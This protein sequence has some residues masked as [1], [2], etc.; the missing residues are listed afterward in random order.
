MKIV[1]SIG[2]FF[3]FCLFSFISYEN[4][5]YEITCEEVKVIEILSAKH[6]SVDVRLSNNKIETVYQPSTVIAKDSPYQY[7]EKV[8]V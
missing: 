5:K 2:L 7:C 1:I 3:L 4:S 8:E 6:R